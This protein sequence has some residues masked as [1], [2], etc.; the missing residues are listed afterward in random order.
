VRPLAGDDPAEIGG[1]RLRAR[2]GAGGM[3]RVYLAATPAGRPVALKVVRPELG[4]DKEFRARFRQEVQAAQ[5]VHGLYTAELVDADP[6]ATPP[7]LVTAY[8]PGPSLEEAIDK[9]G[10]MPAG[11]VL[12][13]IGGVAEALQAIHAADV[14]HRDLKPSNVLLAEDGPRVIDFGIARAAEGARLTRGDIM[15]GSLDFMAPEQILDWPISPAIDVFTLG[16]LAV[17]AATG[18]P[19]FGRGHIAAVSHRVIYSPPDLEGCPAELLTLVEACLEKQPEERPTPERIVDFC[20][21]RAAQMGDSSTPF[22]SW[23]LA[24]ATIEPR[25][26][27]D[28]IADAAVEEQPSTDGVKSGRVKKR[29]LRPVAAVTAGALVAVV[30]IAIT[31]RLAAPG[32]A[33]PRGVT[34]EGTPATHDST[35]P[36]V[37]HSARAASPSRLSK[38]GHAATA[39][40]AAAHGLATPSPA[41]SGSEASASVL[42]S[43]DHPATASSLEGAHWAASNAV[44]GNLRTRWSSAWSDPQW[45]EVDLGATHTISKVVLY[46]ERAYAAAFQIQVSDNGT[47]W[48]DIYST[49]TSIGGNQTL[50]VNGTGRY[51]RMY[52]TKRATTYGYSLWE[53]QVFGDLAASSRMPVPSGRRLRL[54]YRTA[55]AARRQTTHLPS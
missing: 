32:T 10:P 46:W 50:L 38:S 7:W 33:T 15:M 1:Y 51:V 4:D 55:G 6:D 3:A 44:D 23:G 5:R 28:D 49:T 19:P 20:M 43:Q 36:V 30:A 27:G 2:L 18:K 52:G 42:L 17:Y 39:R 8:V 37:R 53:F 11:M 29:R 25:G 14:V 35:A 47:T 9:N 48:T 24:D 21:T 12:R 34:A 13:L 41:A 40:G 45:L 31:L 22:L 26:P 54:Y 16:S